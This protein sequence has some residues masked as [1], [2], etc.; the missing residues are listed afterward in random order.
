MAFVD[1]H[2]AP[3]PYDHFR[4]SFNYLDGANDPILCQRMESQIW[5]DRVPAGDFNQFLHPTN[6]ADQRIFPL[7]KQDPRT[8]RETSRRDLD[9]LK[10]ALQ[11]THKRFSSF[12]G[13]HEASQRLNHLKNRANA[14]LVES[15]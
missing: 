12:G 8:A 11:L 6:S 5:K 4:V 2:A 13:S 9:G 7:L 15:E 10:P 1:L 3:G 14:T